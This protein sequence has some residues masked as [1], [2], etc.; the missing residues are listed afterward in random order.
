MND[1]GCGRMVFCSNIREVTE[2][3]LHLFIFTSLTAI[4]YS[5]PSPPTHSFVT[6]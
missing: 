4:T 2:S 5:T 3:L 1:L 6:V